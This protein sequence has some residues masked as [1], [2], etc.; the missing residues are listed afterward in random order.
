MKG[1]I[2]AGG[3]GTRLHPAKGRVPER[4][5]YGGKSARYNC[6]ISRLGLWPLSSTDCRV[7]RLRGAGRI[8]DLI[9]DRFGTHRPGVS[10]S[11]HDV[12]CMCRRA[13]SRI[14]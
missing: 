13:R 3:L 7:T 11:L 14:L 9:P 2:L 4:F 12:G 10:R 5:H 8:V 6:Q 1:I